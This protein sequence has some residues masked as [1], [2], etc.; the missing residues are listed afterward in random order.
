MEAADVRTVVIDGRIVLRDGVVTTADERE[1]RRQVRA[2]LLWESA[3][4]VQERTPEVDVEP[5]DK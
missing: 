4:F 3:P 5:S 1:I 2:H